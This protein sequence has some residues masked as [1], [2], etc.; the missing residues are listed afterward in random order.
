MSRSAYIKLGGGLDLVTAT[1]EAAPGSAS[2]CVNYEAPVTGGYRRIKGYAQLGPEVP[3][4]GSILGVATFYDRH[5]AIREDAV[6]GTATLYRLSLDGLSWDVMGVGGELA[7]GR[8]EFDEGNAYATDA[9]NALYGVGGGQPF[10]LLQDG[11][12]ATLTNAP[13]GATMIALHHNHLFLGFGQG[14]LQFSGIGDPGNYDAATGGAGEIGVGQLLNGIVRGIG[15]VLHVLTRD[16]VQTLRGTGAGSFLLEVTVPGVGARRYSAQSLMMPYFVTERGITTLASAQE[17]GDFTAL[18][19]GARVEPLF[20]G[21]GLANRVVA[22]SV[23]RNKAQ[24]R[25]FFDNGSGL[26]LSPNGITQVN[27]PDQVAVCHGGELASGD[28]S[29]MMGDDK[30]LVYRMDSGNSFNGVPIRAYLTLAYTDLK[31]PS[32]RKRFRRAFFDVRSGS[33]ASI[34]LWPDFDYGDIET[35]APRRQPIDFM[36]GGGL[37]SVNSWDEFQWSVPFLGQEPLDITGTGTAINFAI[38]SESSNEPH[39]LLGYDLSFDIRR[40]RRG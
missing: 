6:A 12:L 19:P 22:S 2:S 13:S 20:S 29:L 34:W 18:Q 31:S 35:A 4:Q 5:Y 15:G 23:S 40:N 27:F 37:W 1:R 30:G 3:G 39:E 8:H 28:E 14:S 33:N 38:Y 17:F 25:I 36:L 9:G 10:E 32:T 16:S 24:Y 21:A 11:T 7:P 26:Y